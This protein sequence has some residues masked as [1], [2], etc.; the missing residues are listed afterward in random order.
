M[1]KTVDTPSSLV[2]KRRFHRA[3]SDDLAVERILRKK[4]AG[5]FDRWNAAK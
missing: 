4:S 3:N 2:E 1:I 5:F